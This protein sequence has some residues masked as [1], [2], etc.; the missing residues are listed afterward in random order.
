MWATE[1]AMQGMV[2]EFLPPS[3]GEAC[4]AALRPPFRECE[5]RI[6]ERTRRYMRAYRD[7][8]PMGKRRR[9]A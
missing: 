4:D 3:R 6:R 8:G 5:V 9:A 1:R 2:E 7:E